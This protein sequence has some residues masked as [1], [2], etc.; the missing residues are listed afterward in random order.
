MA[1]PYLKSGESIILTTDRVLIDD[2]EYDVILTSQRLALVDS[3]HT[4]DQ[5]QV[6]LFATI[7]SV[8]GGTTPAREPFI[9]LTVIDPIGLEDSKTLDLIF[10]QQPYED[11]SPECDTWVKKLIEH[12]VSAK[13]EP[14]PAERQ[15][16]PVKSPGMSPTVRRWSAPEAPQPHTKVNQETKRPSEELL[17]A[18]QSTSWETPDTGGKA[19]TAETRQSTTSPVPE[20]VQQVPAADEDIPPAMVSKPV[21]LIQETRPEQPVEH[22][23]VR[24]PPVFPE[25]EGPAAV[26]QDAGKPKKRRRSKKGAAPARRS[27]VGGS[28]STGADPESATPKSSKKGGKDH[29]APAPE[30]TVAAL[31]PD[32]G[33]AEPKKDAEI[34]VTI[35]VPEPPVHPDYA[36][37][38]GPREISLPKENAG[39]MPRGPTDEVPE[40]MLPELSAPGSDLPDT[41][42]PPRDE[43]NVR[44]G[45]PDTVVF[46]VIPDSSS[47]PAPETP[48]HPLQAGKDAA[49][50]PPLDPRK[51]P[52]WMYAIIFMILVVLGGT[53]IILLHP[54]GNSQQPDLPVTI[55]PT[56]TPLPTTSVPEMVIPAEGVWVKVT[57]NGTFVGTYGNP[58]E[59]K[60]VRGTG[61]QLYPIKNSNDLVQTSFRKLDYSGDS[62][63]VEVY[64]NGTMVTQVTKRT[65]SGTIAILVD[66]KTGKAP[67]VPVTTIST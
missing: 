11:R 41:P 51:K 43:S 20:P 32:T 28:E 54:G 39:M 21:D 34:P 47:G 12:I 29:A 57:Y 55:S 33:A 35:M 10:S 19:Q 24:S 50:T 8:K 46:P 40:G 62:L 61:E 26:V 17:S 64:N 15:Q 49:R 3:G 42:A 65:P 66:P 18:M 52:V 53:A 4:S 59:L 44:A 36:Q 7:L 13:Q 67:Y 30:E 1:G 6:V 31:L 56:L 2:S 48:V 27:A 63:T 38:Q 37:E 23:E 60:E 16:A 58:G 45:L 9:T 25:L 5:P 22:E 14:A